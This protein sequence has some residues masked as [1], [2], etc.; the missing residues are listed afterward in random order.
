M[1]L[2]VFLPPQ[3]IDSAEPQ[4]D[5]GG[6]PGWGALDPRPRAVLRVFPN[7]GKITNIVNYF[8]SC[9][10]R[11]S[12]YLVSKLYQISNVKRRLIN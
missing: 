3:V 2:R 5:G 1:K 11:K 7:A 8:L 10:S 12:N 6:V 9:F 4:E